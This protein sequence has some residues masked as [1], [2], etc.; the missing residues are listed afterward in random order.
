M[1]IVT[2]K[3]VEWCIFK[4]NHVDLIFM[5][6]VK[7]KFLCLLTLRRQRKLESN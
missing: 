3:T 7:T 1:H 4:L 5:L 6:L 2:K